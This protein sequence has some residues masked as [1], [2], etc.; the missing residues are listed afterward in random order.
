MMVENVQNLRRT[1][2]FVVHAASLQ[3]ATYTNQYRSTAAINCRVK[4]EE[5]LTYTLSEGGRVADS[6][7]FHKR[8]NLIT[9]NISMSTG[10]QIA[11][12][13]QEDEFYPVS[14]SDCGTMV[15]VFDKHQQYHFFN[16]LPSN[17]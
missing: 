10:Q 8:Q 6:Q 3:H 9:G 13:L 11:Q 5:I 14:C 16:A 12:L 15:G 4:R 2:R 17:C 7:P 1:L